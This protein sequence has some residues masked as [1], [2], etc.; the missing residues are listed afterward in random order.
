MGQLPWAGCQSALSPV[1]PKLRRRSKRVAVRSRKASGPQVFVRPT[2]APSEPPFSPER[3]QPLAGA[4]VWGCWKGGRGCF[5]PP[6]FQLLCSLFH[7]MLPRPGVGGSTT[8]RGLVEGHAL[9]IACYSSC[10]THWGVGGS[11]W[12]PPLPRWRKCLAELERKQ[13]QVWPRDLAH[14]A[15][16]LLKGRP[17]LAPQPAVPAGLEP[18]SSRRAA[19]PPTRILFLEGF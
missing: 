6:H 4:H 17:F 10:S 3:Q 1:L 15:A 19:P 11:L 13:V 9:L 14:A 5:Q 18:L 2:L 8:G 16:L 7:L 12:H